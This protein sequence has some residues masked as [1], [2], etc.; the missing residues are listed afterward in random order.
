MST[1][2]DTNHLLFIGASFTPV[3]MRSIAPTMPVTV[4]NHVPLFRWTSRFGYM[5]PDTPVLEIEWLVRKRHLPDEATNNFWV[6]ESF[7]TLARGIKKI[8]AKCPWLKPMFGY[9]TRKS[10]TLLYREVLSDDPDVRADGSLTIERLDFH[11]RSIFNEDD[12]QDA[13]L[14]KH[15]VGGNREE[16]NDFIEDEL[17]EVLPAWWLPQVYEEVVFSEDDSDGSDPNR[18]ECSGGEDSN[19]SDTESEN[20]GRLLDDVIW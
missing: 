13:M 2:H 12:G 7:R 14:L 3:V 1:V 16:S 9:T 15:I 17:P 6:D 18:V 19:H 11:G 20:D 8:R 10:R 4:C 5:R